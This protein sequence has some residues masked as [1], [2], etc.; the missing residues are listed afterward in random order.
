LRGENPK[1]AWYQ[2]EVETSRQ[3]NIKHYDVSLNSHKTPSPQQLTLLKNILE[4]APKPLLIHCR[5]GA[6]RTG[7]VLR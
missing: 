5:A 3:L 2:G 1:Q 4:T 7:L 6:D